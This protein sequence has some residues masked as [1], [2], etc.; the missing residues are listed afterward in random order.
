MVWCGYKSLVTI[1]ISN[2]LRR[3]ATTLVFYFTI[4]SAWCLTGL[5][6]KPGRHPGRNVLVGSRHSTLLG[7][8]HPNGNA[9]AFAVY[10][11]NAAL[12]LYSQMAVCQLKSRKTT[13]C[14]IS[15]AQA[16]VPINGE[17]LD[18]PTAWGLGGSSSVT[19]TKDSYR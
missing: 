8:L 11:L 17:V 16:M 15:S 4:H 7:K 13:R 5:R 3:G 9:R 2:H 19:S 18:S 1:P 14:C 10:D 6:G 12:A